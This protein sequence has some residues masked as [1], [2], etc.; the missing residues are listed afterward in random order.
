MK[1]SLVVLFVIAAAALGFVGYKYVKKGGI[2][3]NVIPSTTTN[4]TQPSGG[5]PNSGSSSQSATKVGGEISLTIDTPA[6]NSTVTSPTVKVSGKTVPNADVSVN[7]TELKAD[8]SGNFSTTVTLDEGENIIGIVA[9]DANGNS[10]EQDLT[11]TY[12]S[13]Q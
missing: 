1:N 12:N 13:G 6:N 8:G 11:V 5:F 3:Y 9:N 4:Q 10:S 2:N 7:D